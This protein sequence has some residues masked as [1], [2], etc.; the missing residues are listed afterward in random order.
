[1]DAAI[2]RPRDFAKDK[3]YP[4]IL[5]VYAGPGHKQVVAQPDRYM[6]DQWMADRGYIVVAIDGRGNAGSRPRMGA[7]DPRKFDRR[8][9]RGP[10]RG[11]AGARET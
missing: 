6:I 8:R 5:D 3:H 2:V 7:R 9:A 1:M 10:D 4:V 11:F